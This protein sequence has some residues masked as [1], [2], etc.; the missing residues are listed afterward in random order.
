MNTLFVK[1]KCS[2][3]ILIA[4]VPIHPILISAPPFLA[5]MDAM[6]FIGENFYLSRCWYPFFVFGK[7]VLSVL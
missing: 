2:P 3:K 1:G 7:Q 5:H 6:Y 4:T